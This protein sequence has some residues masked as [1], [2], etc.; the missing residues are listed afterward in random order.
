MSV[1][2]KVRRRNVR[3]RS[4]RLPCFVAYYFELTVSV[5]FI[6]THGLLYIRPTIN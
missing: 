2:R 1:R 3:R 4:V 5:L 6:F